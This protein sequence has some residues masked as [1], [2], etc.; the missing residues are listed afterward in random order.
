MWTKWAKWA[1]SEPKMSKER[2]KWTNNEPRMS[3]VSQVS[4]GWAKC[5]PGLSKVWAKSELRVSQGKAKSEPS[6]SSQPSHPIK[7]CALS[8][9]WVSQ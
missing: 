3:R 5:E 1:M 4:Q 6:Q 7:P 2:A 9:P 8:E